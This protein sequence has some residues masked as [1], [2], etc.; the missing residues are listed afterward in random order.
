MEVV[1]KMIV[2]EQR[3]PKIFL[4]GSIRG[5]RQLLE[6]YRLMY[7]TLEDAGA[8]VLRNS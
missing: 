3:S 2:S 4:S 8:E 1:E 6:I 5:R 7:H